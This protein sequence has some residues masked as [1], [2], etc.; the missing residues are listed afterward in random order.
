MSTAPRLTDDLEHKILVWIRSG[1]FPH[2]AAAAEGVAPEVFD[3]WLERGT[4]K[5]PRPGR[6]YRR[7]ARNVLQAIGVARIR[8]EIRALEKDPKFWLLSGPGKD[9]PDCPGWTGAVRARAAARPDEFNALSDPVLAPLLE[10][11]LVA[12]L[13]FPEARLAAVQTLQKFAPGS[14]AGG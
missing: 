2:I 6:R 13:P 14:A 10:Q 4:R 11:L 5:T 8:A 3:Q 9:R 12:L 7:F 1:A